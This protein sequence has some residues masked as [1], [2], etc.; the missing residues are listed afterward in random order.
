[1]LPYY[2]HM[3][4]RTIYL[5]DELDWISREL[6][7]NLSQLTQSAL[8]ALASERSDEVLDGRVGAAAARIAALELEWPSEPLASQRA[9]A[10]ER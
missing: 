3:P 2:M 9:E 6:G 10:G 8:K 7:V 4:N 1:M 5:P